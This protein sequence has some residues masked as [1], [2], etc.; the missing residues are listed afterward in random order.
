MLGK[1]KLAS[2]KPNSRAVIT[3]SADGSYVAV[4]WP[5]AATY[6]IFRQGVANWEE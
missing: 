6:C 4:T 2:A 1:L 5:A 3:C